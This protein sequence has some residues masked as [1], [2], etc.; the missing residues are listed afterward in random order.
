MLGLGGPVVVS[1]TPEGRSLHLPC[2]YDHTVDFALTGAVLPPEVVKKKIIQKGWKVGRRLLCP[3][4]AT[5]LRVATRLTYP[6]KRRKPPMPEVSAKVTP[7]TPTSEE[8]RTARRL[9]T[10]LIE[11]QFDV[12]GGFY[13]NGYTDKKVADETGVSEHF[14][15]KRREEDFGPLK[16]P[17]EIVKA[18]AEIDAL[19]QRVEDL[20]AHCAQVTEALMRDIAAHRRNLSSLIAKNGWAT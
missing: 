13:R 4:H 18:K 17:P 16:D 7:I 15:T 3:E 11:E 14:V 2:Y 19:Q 9:A 8:A 10:L 20:K 5:T 1:V 12:A 6:E